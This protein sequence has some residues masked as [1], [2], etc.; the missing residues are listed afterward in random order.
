MTDT[1]S[2]TSAGAAEAEADLE[3]S[4]RLTALAANPVD[5]VPAAYLAEAAAWH[6]AQAEQE[7]AR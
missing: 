7:G 2:L 5:D 3:F 4:A 6:A 1:G